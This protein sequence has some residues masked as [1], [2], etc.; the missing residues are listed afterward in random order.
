[1]ILVKRHAVA[2]ERARHVEQGKEAYGPRAFAQA[3]ARVDDGGE[4]ELVHH[5][6]RRRFGRAVRG[7]HEGAARR[8]DVAGQKRCNRADEA[9]DDDGHTLRSA[10]QVESHKACDVEASQ[11]CEHVEGIVCVGGVHLKRALYDGDLACKTLV[12]QARPSAH[13][14]LG[15]HAHKGAYQRCRCCGV[16]D[17]H[18]ACCH[19]AKALVC[20][21]VRDVRA[22]LHSRYGLG[23]AHGRALR[24]G[25]RPAR[26]VAHGHAGHL[27]EHSHVE[28]SHLGVGHAGHDAYARGVMRKLR[29][30]F[31][32]HLGSRLRHTFGHHAVVGAHHGHAAGRERDLGV[33]LDAGDVFHGLLERPQ[34]AQR[35]GH[36]CPAAV[37]LLH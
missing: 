9:V 16:A 2:V 6:S 36:A 11:L 27:V 21:V 10:P 18:L 25:V 29:G 23:A 15:R 30:Y 17:A 35:L 20:Q 26:G 34:A 5:G 24:D 14:R 37:R 32:G 3:H 8:G 31:G 4:A 7:E 13:G 28:G 1:M 22:C 33:A 12:V 19:E